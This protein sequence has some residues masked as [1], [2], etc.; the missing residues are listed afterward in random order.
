MQ[1]LNVGLLPVYLPYGFAPVPFG[2]PFTTATVTSAAPGVFTVPGYKP[3]LNDAVQ[4][5]VAALS[6][7]TL[8]T[9]FTAGI[10][11]YAVNITTAAGTFSLSTQ[12]NGTG[13]STQAV[14]VPGPL[15]VHL[16]SNQFDGTLCPFETGATVLAMNLSTA[17][18]FL[19]GAPDTNLAPSY[20][21]PTGPG[22]KVL[23]TGVPA[24][25]I[26]ANS[27]ALVTLSQDWILTTSAGPG[28]LALLQN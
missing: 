6:T 18:I 12:K 1:L 27:M 4:L 2:D 22:T 7:A 11:Y 16:V 20:G 17:A 15:T 23:L 21:N 5:S 3:L 10:T 26:P 9:A 14:N 25:G 13:Q 8:N 24:G 28:T 19:Q